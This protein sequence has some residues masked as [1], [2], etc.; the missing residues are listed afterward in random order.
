MSTRAFSNT[1]RINSSKSAENIKSRFR[2]VLSERSVSKEFESDMTNELV[3]DQ[4][5]SR[6][7]RKNRKLESQLNEKFEKI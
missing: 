7:S 2:L 4:K 1:Q 3:D 6:Q 5:I